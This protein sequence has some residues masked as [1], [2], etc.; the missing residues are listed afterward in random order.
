MKITEEQII[1]LQKDLWE[2]KTYEVI[3]GKDGAIK[4]LLKSSLENILNAELSEY[5]AYEK[6]SLHL[7]W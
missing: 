5:L 7:P 4:K 2:E 1:Q 6:H 3:M